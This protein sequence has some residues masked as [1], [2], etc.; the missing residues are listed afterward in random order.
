MTI[1]KVLMKMQMHFIKDIRGLPL[2]DQ[3]PKDKKK[4]MIF[5]GQELNR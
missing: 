1:L 2:P 5:Y 3:L 4:L